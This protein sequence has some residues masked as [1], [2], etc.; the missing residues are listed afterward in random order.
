MWTVPKVAAFARGR[1]GVE[2]RDQT[3]RVWLRR[4]G[5]R[6]KVPGPAT[7]AP[8]R[9][10]SSGG[11]KGGLG[12]F[13]ADRRAEAPGREGEAWGEDERRLGLKPAAR[14]ARCPRG[15]RP[16]CGGRHRS[17]WLCA[18]G[19]ARPSTGQAVSVILPRVSAEPTGHELAEFA[20]AAGPEGRKPLVLPVGNAG[21]R[22]ARR[23]AVPAN[24]AL[25]RLPPFT[26]ELRPAER[27]WP[28]L[29]EAVANRDLAELDARVR[30]RAEWLAAHPE[31]A[32]CA[33]GFHRAVALTG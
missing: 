33:V 19:F 16:T 13:V 22:V 6:L 12:E 20:R 30:R 23:L 29:R 25:C 4:L 3:G 28:L 24:L 32:R 11:G 5:F 14:R 26:P 10:S 15:Q 31:V 21:W 7:R 9:P 1:F 27:L 2:V 17:E 8:R 18:C